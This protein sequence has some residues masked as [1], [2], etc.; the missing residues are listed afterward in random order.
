VARGRLENQLAAL[1]FP[2]RANMADERLTQHLCA[3][4]GELVTFLRQLG[5]G[6][7]DWRAEL[8]VRFGVILRKA[9][10]GS[11]A[12]AGAQAQ[13]GVLS[14]R[15]TRGQQGRSAPDHLSRLPRGTPVALV[16]PS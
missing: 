13:S 14:A 1:A 16:L 7:T 11:R 12:W 15:Q 10:G 5:L 8:A 9:W 3:R 6:A 2:H 4:H